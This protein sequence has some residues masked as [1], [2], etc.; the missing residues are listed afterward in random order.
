ML[1][2]TNSSTI[3]VSNEIGNDCFGGFSPIPDG[4]GDGPI[5]TIAQLNNVINSLRV[6]DVARPITV[7]FMGECQ[8][9]Q[10]IKVGAKTVNSFYNDFFSVADITFES[11]PGTRARLIGGKK[12]KGFKEDVFNGTPCLSLFIPEVKSG[13]WHFT[14]LYVNG[15]PAK[16]SRYPKE[17]TLKA[18]TTEN[19]SWPLANSSKWFIAFKEDLENISGV[20]DAIVSFNHFWIDEHSPVESYDRET[21][22]LVLKYPSRFTI[23]VNYE[24]NASSDLHYYLENVAETFSQPEEWFLDVKNGML[25]YIPNEGETVDNLEFIAPTLKHFAEIH[26]TNDNKAVG[27][28]FRN[29]DLIATKGD[30]SSK[31]TLATKPSEP[32]KEYAADAQSCYAAHGAIRFENAEVCSIENCNISCT[33]V[34]AIEIN[35]GCQNIRIE[36]NSITNCGGGGVKIWG[37]AATEEEDIRPTSFNVIR[38]NTIKDCGKRWAASC[39]ILVCHSAHNEISENEISDLEYS[40]ISVGWVWGYARSTTYGNI[41]RNNHIHHIGKGRLSDMGGIYLLG[42]QHGTVVSGNIVHDV[43]SSNYGGMG[44]YTDEGSSYITVENNIV[45]RCKECCYQHHYGKHNTIRGNVFAFAGRALFDVSRRED[46]SSVLI[47]ENTFISDGAPMYIAGYKF[48]G[49]DF[50]SS[51]NTYWDLSGNEPLMIKNPIGDIYFKDWQEHY[52]YDTESIVKKPSA[53]ILKKVTEK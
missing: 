10:S 13:K 17:G 31:S 53:K 15:K 26:G 46:R 44:I 32:P 34:H 23:T 42:A 45:F 22:K 48:L 2:S 1:N 16:L 50:T 52:G 30:Y 38:K 51:K 20:E 39:G 40:G 9:D 8:L 18:V 49:A 47:E 25:Y 7:R 27:V 28:R 11:Q 21:G 35:K 41:I 5:K 24:N 12:L 19:P 3:Y 37:S 6:G 14:D 4:K 43:I 29:L 33:G 36:N